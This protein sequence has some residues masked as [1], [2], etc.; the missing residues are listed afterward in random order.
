LE[1][2]AY[3]LAAARNQPIDI[4]FTLS[5]CVPAT[6]MET[7]GARLTAET[8][9]PL[10]DHAGIVALA[11]MMNFPGV[12]MADPA[13]LE[14][15]QLARLARKPVDGHAPGLSGM[16]LNA[17]VAAG[18][19]SDHECTTAEEAR[20][21]LAAGM[22]IMVRESTG[23]KNL[24]ALL[25]VINP[26]TAGRM[27]WCTDDRHPHDL[28]DDG[29]IDSIVRRAIQSGLDPLTAIRMAT[30]H[31][32][33][34]F[35]LKDSGA[36]APGRKANLLVLSDLD[37]LTIEQVYSRGR[38]V[39][40]N[41]SISGTVG[42]PPSVAVPF[43]MQVDL[44]RLDLGI[45]AEGPRIR[46]IEIVP[47]QI[48]TGQII[49]ETPLSNDLAAADPKRDLLK[50]VVVERHRATGR[51]GKGFVRGIG[52]KQGALASSVAHDSHNIVAVGTND[53]DMLTAIQ[54][55]ATAGGGLAAVH[56]GRVAAELALPIAGLMSDQPLETVRDRLDHLIRSAHRMGAVLAD[57]FMTLSF[58]ALPV[59]P[60]L[61]LT[62][63]GLVD[64]DRFEFVS[65]FVD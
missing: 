1:G 60:A 13:V 31:P 11:E 51:I 27:M 47:D 23:A 41:G 17:Y 24:E 38:L 14:K 36:V 61:K 21:K 46:V 57:P 37:N 2:I 49:V 59:I 19:S 34:Y 53:A 22:H 52:L 20:E 18:I 12:V 56:E 33:E 42:R 64:V 40:E 8:L 63:R 54:A 65:L 43:G 35:G 15:I 6:D 44:D 7:A 16:Q 50:M 29:H 5:S 58:L 28:I 10:I 32:A 62:D 9:Q 4:Y 26:Q 55:V 45:P 3:M 30:L 25:P 39:A 48:V